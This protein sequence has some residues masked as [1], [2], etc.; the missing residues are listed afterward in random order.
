MG[1]PK[2]KSS[3]I[4]ISRN[5][6]S[7]NVSNLLVPNA[8]RSNS[9]NSLN[10]VNSCQKLDSGPPWLKAAM[11]KRQQNK[12]NSN[13][14]FL[15]DTNKEKLAAFFAANCH[16]RR[17]KNI[18]TKSKSYLKCNFDTKLSWNKRLKE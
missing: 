8:S 15:S 17:L 10:R 2:N 6:S 16:G 14:D 11:K 3:Q 13:E 1:I 18:G 12:N 9:K 7:N 4:L 5:Q